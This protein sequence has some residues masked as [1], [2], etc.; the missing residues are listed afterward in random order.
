MS[1]ETLALMRER[2]T[3]FTPTLSF[4]IDMLEPGG[5]YDHATLTARAREM[6]PVGRA[7][8]AQAAK[9][10]VRIASIRSGSATTWSAGAS[11]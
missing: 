8:V 3:C 11:R 1:V 9:T 10:G 4:W 6:L 2:A 5:E 7:A